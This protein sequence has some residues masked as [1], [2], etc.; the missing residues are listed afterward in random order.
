MDFSLPP[1][2]VKYLS[3]LDSFIEKKINPLQAKDDNERFFN[4]RREHS[5]T[6]WDN[7]GLPRKDWERLLNEAKR[8]ADDAGHLRFALPNE[9]GGQG[10]S[11]TNLWMAV[12]RDHLAA[13]GLGLFNDL[14]N[15]HSIVGN[16]PVVLMFREFGN[17]TAKSRVHR[18]KSQR[19]KA[20]MLWLDRARARE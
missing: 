1:A 19:D 6:D 5:R 20:S 4:H 8:L 13:K 2:L 14:Q 17:P 12:I 18:G 11:L 16:F 3:I 10:H 9:Y 15:E 7:R